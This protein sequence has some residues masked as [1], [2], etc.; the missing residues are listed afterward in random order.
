M[1]TKKTEGAEKKE[2]GSKLALAAALVGAAAAGFYLYGAKG[3][4]NRKKIKAWTIKAKG[5]ILEQFEK[6]KELTEDQYNEV[7]DKITAKYG[8]LKTIGEEESTKLNREL[9]KHW[10]AIKT[11]IETAPAKKGKK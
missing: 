5:E 2:G 11:G 8:K 7:V 10:K 6:K 9:K 1:A 3:N 4:E